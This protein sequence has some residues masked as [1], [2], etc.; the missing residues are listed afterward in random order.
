MTDILMDLK[1]DYVE[2]PSIKQRFDQAADEIT[3]LRDLVAE[4]EA[5][6]RSSASL[7]E[8][9]GTAYGMLW[10]MKVD[11][12]TKEGLMKSLARSGL[13]ELLTPDEQAD[14]IERAKSRIE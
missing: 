14:G 5:K 4:L 13:R 7:R 1:T 11:T 2:S 9:C 3:R 8:A 12:S 10:M 6:V